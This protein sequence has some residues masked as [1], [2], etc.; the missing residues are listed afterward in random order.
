MAS[1]LKALALSL[2]PEGAVVQK[3][4]GHF[5]YLTF[6]DGPDPGMT[7]RVLDALGKSDAKATFF[8]QGQC[9][10][11]H[12]GVVRRIV[13]EG[14]AIAGH[15]WSHRRLP[16]WDFRGVWDEFNR[17]REAIR[18][19]VAVDTRLYRPAFGLVTLPMLAYAAVGKMKLILW[20]VDSDDD[21]TRSVSAVL[22]KGRQVQGGDIF[23]CHDDNEAILGAIPGLL[24]EWRARGLELCVLGNDG[25]LR[26]E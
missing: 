4:T 26:S 2:L 3:K 13:E 14:H 8:V 20:S 21:R 25:N 18:Q 1:V 7:P 12:P 11:R 16:Q 10:I 24:R 22:A 15:S 5:V 17:T 19:A 6:D 9:V 23:L